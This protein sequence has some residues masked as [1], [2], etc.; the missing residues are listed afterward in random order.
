MK[1]IKKISLINRVAS[2]EGVIVPIREEEERKQMFQVR[3]ANDRIEDARLL[4]APRKLYKNTSLIFENELTI[5]FAST[6]VG[7][8]IKAVQMANEIAKTDKVLYF[9]L[10]LSDV[11]FRNRYSDEFV[12][13]FQFSDNLFVVNFQRGFSLP[14]G[15]TYDDY[16]L[17]SLENLIT[18]TGAKIVF[19]DNMT[20]LISADTDKAQSAKPLM[21]RLNELK[22]NYDLT[23]VLLEHTRKTNNTQPI[24]VNDLQGSKFKANFA[25]A[26]FCI[27]ESAKDKNFR[28][29]KQLK[30][31]SAEFEF[32]AENVAIYE[33][34]KTDGFLHFEFKGYSTERE[35]LRLITEEDRASVIE[36]VKEMVDL[37]YSQ[38]SIA[39]KLKLSLGVVNKYSKL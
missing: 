7:K 39:D 28:Y 32:D 10:E 24:S 15:V 1:E 25:D 23:M 35:H 2:G 6:G 34:E 5:L 12:G 20:R 37:G 13:D 19:V 14:S 29:I 11:Q 17:E 16:F 31:R 36:K 22:F 38:R 26:V 18:E 4:S 21:D 33:I 3:G 9:D 30:V 27:G 8:T